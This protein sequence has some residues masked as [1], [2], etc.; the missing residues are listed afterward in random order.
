MRW[1]VFTVLSAPKGSTSLAGSGRLGTAVVGMALLMG[2]SI[3]AC[4]MS[5]EEG[6]QGLRLTGP[7]ADLPSGISQLRFDVFYEGRGAST[8]LRIGGMGGLPEMPEFA[9]PPLLTGLPTGEPILVR[10]VGSD[11]SRE[12]LG[13]VGPVVLGP[14]ERFYGEVRVY[15]VGTASSSGFEG[16]TPRFLHSATTL[17][18]GRVLIAG[19]FTSASPLSTCPAEAPAGAVACFELVATSDALIFDANSGRFFPVR[20]SML[21][22]RAGHS[23]TV[24]DGRVLIAGGATRAV[25]ALTE[26]NAA[27]SVLVPSFIPFATPTTPG[28]L[29]TFEL[30]DPVIGYEEEDTD[31]NGDP[32]AG[33]F[34]GGASDAG[35]VGELNEPRLHARCH[36]QPRGQPGAPRWGHRLRPDL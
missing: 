36:A 22:A 16:F 28:G 35:A 23:A 6:V 33:G 3:A 27:G 18:D 2:G 31:R 11:G 8:T 32:G 1:L 34:L 29:A 15:E 24:V 21:S 4:S 20:G 7:Q 17:P 9:S 10:V 13:H 30:F 19:G 5:P 25:L 12:W 14:G 26:G